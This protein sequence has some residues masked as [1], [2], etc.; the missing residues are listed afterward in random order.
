MPDGGVEKPKALLYVQLIEAKNVPRIDWLSKT[1]PYVKYVCSHLQ[2]F[3]IG[4]RCDEAMQ[5]PTL[6]LKHQQRCIDRAIC[7]QCRVLTLCTM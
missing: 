3:V 5:H 6:C 1:D 7:M 4:S 2:A